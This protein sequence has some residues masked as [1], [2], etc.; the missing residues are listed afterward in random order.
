MNSLVFSRGCAAASLPPRLGKSMSPRGLRVRPSRGVRG[1]LV[2]LALSWAILASHAA[3]PGPP[4]DFGVGMLRDEPGDEGCASDP[5]SCKNGAL[6]DMVLNTCACKQWWTG[7]RCES[8][9]QDMALRCVEEGD[10]QRCACAPEACITGPAL[11]CDGRGSCV[12][13]DDG[14]PFCRCTASSVQRGPYSCVAKG[15]IEG[16]LGTG[17]ICNG[18]G[19]CNASGACS[20]PFGTSGMRCQ[21]MSC[22]AAADPRY[23][24]QPWAL[25]PMVYCNLGGTCIASIRG[26]DC[27]CLANYAGIFCEDH[28]CFSDAD[29]GGHGLCIVKREGL[30]AP[31]PDQRLS[32]VCSCFEP[33]DGL[34]C[35]TNPCACGEA[36]AVGN[37]CCSGGGLCAKLSQSEYVV[38]A[39]TA[40]S[41]F[42]THRCFCDSKSHGVTCKGYQ[43]YDAEADAPVPGACMNGVC[44]HD[45]ENP[46]TDH[47]SRCPLYFGGRDC[48]VAFC[49]AEVEETED[50]TVLTLCSGRG[51][52]RPSGDAFSCICVSGYA[53]PACDLQDCRRAGCSNRGWCATYSSGDGAVCDCDDCYAGVYCEECAV[54]MEWYIM[55]LDQISYS[56]FVSSR[57]VRR[58]LRAGERACEEGEG[59]EGANRRRHPDPEAS[60]D[61]VWADAS[62]PAH[63]R[64]ARFDPASGITTIEVCAHPNCVLN[65]VVCSNHGSCS[66]TPGGVYACLCESDYTVRWT[67]EC[68]HN[69]C[70][71]YIGGQQYFCGY[72]GECVLED[73]LGLE[74]ASSPAS[75]KNQSDD[76]PDAPG[77]PGPH[78]SA[79]PSLRPP[80]SR[81]VWTCKCAEGMQKDSLTGS[82]FPSSCFYGGASGPAGKVCDGRGNCQYFP[83]DGVFTC[84]CQ[85]NY[86]LKNHGCRLSTGIVVAIVVPVVLAV[87]ALAG[88]LAWLAFHLQRKKRLASARRDGST[89]RRKLLKE[90]RRLQREEAARQLQAG[91]RGPPGPPL[92]VRPPPPMEDSDVTRIVSPELR[93][94]SSRGCERVAHSDEERSPRPARQA[95]ASHPSHPSRPDLLCVSESNVEGIS[96]GQKNP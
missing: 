25:R 23:P 39:N 89:Q 3:S 27:E 1:V 38:P 60:L 51:R 72:A 66:A 43:C 46:E 95:W 31:H 44:K 8:C 16:D 7:P 75:S 32:G 63:S 15:C 56:W 19:Y 41:V 94:R 87:L 21:I 50:E 78:S 40:A 33:Y 85:K 64:G 76:S 88:L 90:V 11:V 77:S 70:V 49:A 91:A 35:S 58:L 17:P 45:E 59:S 71:H 28:S 20:C 81:S 37:D 24:Q 47:C 84:V 48:S 83:N 93:R 61:D 82:C 96:L 54:G 53:G 9:P 22:A 79:A 13:A 6:C 55:E 10:T 73:R 62:S 18:I 52:C 86:S 14:T 74:P 65:G 4:P 69:N 42:I 36:P 2:W 68:I 30:D 5:S 12:V 34:G 26:F 80:A 67:N 57:E 92:V 29:C